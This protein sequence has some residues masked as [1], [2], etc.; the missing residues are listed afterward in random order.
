MAE[1]PETTDVLEED[2][3]EPGRRKSVLRRLGI[4]LISG[5][6]RW[7]WRQAALCLPLGIL[8]AYVLKFAIVFLYAGGYEKWREQWEGLEPVMSPAMPGRLMSLA[9]LCGMYGVIFALLSLLGLRRRGW[10]LRMLRK[11]YS[12]SYILYGWY[13]ITLFHFTGAIEDCSDI[14]NIPGYGDVNAINLFDLGWD[15]LW[16]ASLAVFTMGVLHLITWLRRTMNLYTGETDVTPAVGDRI[17]ENIRTNGRDPAWRRSWVNSAF[18]HLMIIVIIPWLLQFWG[19][20]DPYRPPWG[21]GDPVVRMLT[22]VKPKKK[23]KRKKYILN[24]N[25]PF[26]F[27]IPDLDDSP[28]IRQVEEHTQVRYVADANAAH[29]ERLGDGNAKVAGWQDGFKDGKVRFIRLQYNGEEWDDGM[30]SNE[31]ADMNFLETFRELSGGQK[32]GNKPEAHAIRLLARYPKG[33]APPFVYMTGCGSIRGVSNRDCKI[34]REYMM[35]GGMLFA[36][37]GGPQWHGEFLKFIRRVLPGMQLKKIADDDP[38]FQI[39]FA[40]P[41]GAPS[42]WHHGGYDALG[43]KYRGRWIVFYHPGDIN[44]AWKT[45]HS[46]MQRDRA[47][48]AFH[49]GVNIIY[50]SFMNY[51]RE[52]RKYRKK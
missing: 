42:L 18:G 43:V 9:L 33:Q 30:D 37:C 35:G 32:I 36:D 8:A 40:F 6:R 26:I 34:L 19:C 27:Q 46:G 20:V 3:E 5:W 51:I 15:Y 52:T 39:P 14:D 7:T 31:R 17:L 48:G 23:K 49:M 1:E 38:I 41:N 44:D 16:P 21:G 12:I 11:A 45:G 24:P 13:V 10:T 47:Q 25:S 28:I 2:R 29:G 50:Y 4:R 22:V